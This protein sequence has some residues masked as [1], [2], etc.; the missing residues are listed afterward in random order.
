MNV[1][2]VFNGMSAPVTE[3]RNRYGSYGVGRDHVP[4]IDWPLRWITA[5]PVP[6][7][8]GFG[9]RASTGDGTCVVKIST[10][11][12]TEIQAP[13]AATCGAKSCVRR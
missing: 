11:L 5:V 2:P 4:V 7:V 10:T 13:D 3:A 6:T 8:I 12:R 1:R 9:D